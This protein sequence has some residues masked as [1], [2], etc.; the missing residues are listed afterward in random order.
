VKRDW[1]LRLAGV[2]LA[3]LLVSAA[4][5]AAGPYQFFS[6]TPCRLVDTRGPTG[7]TGGPSLVGNGTRS[8]P[9]DVAPTACG[10]PSTAAAAVLNFAVVGPTSGGHIRTWPFNTAMPLVATLNFDPNEPAIANGAI[11]PLT[12]DPNFQISIFLGT[13]VGPTANLVIDVTGYFQ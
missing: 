10:I 12:V 3:A 5:Q 8:F 6:V 11:V 4:A 9:V 2:G 1:A 7:V 13:G